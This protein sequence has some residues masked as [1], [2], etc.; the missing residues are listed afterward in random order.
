MNPYADGHH[1]IP[2][3][4]QHTPNPVNGGA[5]GHANGGI[6][7]QPL[8]CS[9]HTRPV[10]HLQFSNLMPNDEYLLISACKDGNPMLRSWLGDWIGTF[11]GHKGAVW[12]SKMSLDTSRAITGSADFTAKI[13]DTNSGEALHTFSHNH[14]VRTVALNPQV[15]PQYLLT[16]GHE[17]KIR[18]FDLNRAEADPIVLGNRTDKLST[19]GIV[20][21]IVWDEAQG[22]TV[23]VSAS[24]DGKVRWWDLRTLSE[25]GSLDVGAPISS[26]ELAHGGGTLSV[27]AGN[28]VHFLDIL[29]QHPPVTVNLPHQVTSASLHPFLRDR[30]VAGSTADP[31]VRVYDLDSGEEKEVY[32]G[33]H[34][35]VLCASY[36]PDGE[37]YATGSE[38]GT[39]RLWQTS[40]GKSY[41]LW[42]AQE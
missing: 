38:D 27:A 42:Q 15:E 20:K 19:D 13:W 26:M 30:F 8:L 23:C 9:G 21:S 7:V 6:K 5:N 1:S 33:H 10:V 24:E 40:P 39:I 31:W 14:I 16:G 32:K 4:G 18:L 36:S 3:S 35:P 11:L 12:C 28:D 25:V 2:A 37:V 29:R 17:K 22:G 41:G 34:G